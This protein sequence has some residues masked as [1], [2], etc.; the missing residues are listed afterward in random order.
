MVVVVMA[1]VVVVEDQWEHHTTKSPLSRLSVGRPGSPSPPGGGKEMG[2]ED[3]EEKEDGDKNR[4]EIGCS[5][6]E[7]WCQ[8]WVNVSCRRCG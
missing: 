8:R 1:V 2:A 6:G 3:G 7:G 5:R 4:G